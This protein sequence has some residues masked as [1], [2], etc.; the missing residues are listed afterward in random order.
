M[1][2]VTALMLV[3]ARAVLNEDKATDYHQ[4]RAIYAQ[5]VVGS[6]IQVS[7]NAGPQLVMGVNIIAKTTYSE[8]TQSSECTASDPEV[9]SQITTFWNSLAGLD[10]PA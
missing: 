6:P 1:E 2:R 8:Q 5:Q 9:E 10:T 4:G 7:T 3:V